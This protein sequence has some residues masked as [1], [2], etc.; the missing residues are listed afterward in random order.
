MNRERER[1]RERESKTVHLTQIF[2]NALLKRIQMHDF[3][4]IFDQ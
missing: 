2:G 4:S 3:L 1:E